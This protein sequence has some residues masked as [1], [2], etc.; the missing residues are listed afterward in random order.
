[1]GSPKPL[2]KINGITFLERM[3]RIFREGGAAPV[4]VVLGHE[5]GTIQDALP[6]IDADVIIN[7]EY[8]RGQLSSIRCG[9]RSLDSREIK[10]TL[11][12]PVDLPLISP[13]LVRTLLV[14]A[15][16]SEYG[17][18]IP[19]FRQR[20]GHPGYFSRRLFPDLLNAPDD[21]GARW[22]FRQHPGEVREIATDDEGS[23]LNI[24]TPELYSAHINAHP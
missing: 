2:L 10:G 24:N 6:Q 21:Q 16:S 13:E 9:I 1:M 19:V 3:I 5:A 23:I 15:E 12:S 4:V 22:V 18:I 17:I 20:R 8:E 7:R 11:I 14:S